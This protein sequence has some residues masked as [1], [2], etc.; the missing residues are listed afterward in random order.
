MAVKTTPKPGPEK[1]VDHYWPPPQGEWTYD[2]YA[3][4]PDNGMRYEVIEGDLYMNPAPRPKHQRVIALLY[5]HL[6]EYLK[7]RPGGEVFFAPIDVNLPDL[8][9]PV[10][11]DLLFIAADHLDIVK[12]EFIEGVPDLIVEVLSPGNPTHDRITKFQVY[13][14]AGVRE[15]WLIDPDARQVEINV[16]R[17]QAYAALGVFGPADEIRSEVLA[18]FTIPVNEICPA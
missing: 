11:P 14:R 6:W 5:G 9:S 3:H 10:Q 12:A 7:D 4:L 17:G 18:D 16:L 8:T 1:A 2:D 15:Y 13:A